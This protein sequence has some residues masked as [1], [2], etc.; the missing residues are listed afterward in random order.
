[1]DLLAISDRNVSM[2]KIAFGK[3]VRMACNAGCNLAHSSSALTGVL[4]GRVEHAPISIISAPWLRSSST[5]LRRESVFI[6][7]HDV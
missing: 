2:D 1:M 6:S 5:C 3:C 4:L 7:L